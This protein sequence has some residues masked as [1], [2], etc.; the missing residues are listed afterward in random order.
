MIYA[1]SVQILKPVTAPNRVFLKIKCQ[2]DHFKQENKQDFQSHL[3]S[4]QN[5]NYF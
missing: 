2:L 3:Y 4:K 5:V 1:A